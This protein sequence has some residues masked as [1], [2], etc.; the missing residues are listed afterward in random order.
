M[1]P[2]WASCMNQTGSRGDSEPW[3][4]VFWLQINR[5]GRLE[6]DARTPGREAAP[7]S[8][9][10]AWAQAVGT[11][12]RTKT[13][14]DQGTEAG[15]LWVQ[16]GWEGSWVCCRPWLFCRDSRPGSTCP[17]VHLSLGPPAPGSTCPGRHGHTRSPPQALQPSLS[18]MPV[19]Y[20][21]I[22][23]SPV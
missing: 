22:A 21:P 6:W 7:S 18:E 15:A 11:Q 3:R 5:A 2:T 13:G 17:W 20:N 19:R 23:V 1:L 16:Q 9:G 14:R 10:S 8:R 12:T 4:F